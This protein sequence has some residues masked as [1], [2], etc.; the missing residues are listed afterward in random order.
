[1]G[2]TP[3]LPPDQPSQE[4]RRDDAGGD[5]DGD[6]R[7]RRNLESLREGVLGCD[8][9][10]VAELSGQAIDGLGGAAKRVLRRRGG[11]GRYTTGNGVRDLAPVDGDTDASQDGDPE[12]T[13]ELGAGLRDPRRDTG[14]LRCHAAH[15]QIGSECDGWRDAQ[16]DDD[17]GDH[18]QRDA[19]IRFD[20]GEQP[21]PRGGKGETLPRR[22]GQA[23]RCVP[24][25]ERAS[26]RR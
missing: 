25:A 15:N 10:R 3:L 23:A 22:R 19:R 21:E 12:R 17:R 26:T 11:L 6:S 2:R 16:R 9:Q 13:A 4:D 14:P 20:L 24:G 5:C 1:M 18:D 8:E 7:Q